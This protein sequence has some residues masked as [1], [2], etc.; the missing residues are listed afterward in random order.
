LTP[1]KYFL[2]FLVF[3][4]LSSC[5]DKSKSEDPMIDTFIRLI[6]KSNQ[7]H[8]AFRHGKDPAEQIVDTI[9]TKIREVENLKEYIQQSIKSDS[10]YH[11]EGTIT[12]LNRSTEN[13]SIDFGLDPGCPAFYFY[14][15]GKPVTFKMP[16]RSER[17]LAEIKKS[18]LSRRKKSE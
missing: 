8:I 9:I 2:A 1:A 10:C 5:L 6:D 13:F 3:I 15:E 14:I 16:D 11:L 4:S 7:I 18:L 17:Y 12:F